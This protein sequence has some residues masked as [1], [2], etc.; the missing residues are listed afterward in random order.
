M[1]AERMLDNQ[2]LLDGLGQGTLVFDSAD[3]LVM[4]NQAARALLGH[5]IR[6]F[7]INGWPGANGFFERYLADD[8]ETL[9]QIRA[10]ALAS[11]RPIRFQIQRNGEIIPCW[12]SAV[13]REGGEI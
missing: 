5:D 3:R 4:I 12:A 7:H 11:E 10:R 9:D 13:H 2:A 1:T 8:G 6:A